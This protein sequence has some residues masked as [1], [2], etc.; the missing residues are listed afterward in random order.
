VSEQRGRGDVVAGRFRLIERLGR[1]SYGVV[2]SADDLDRGGRVAIKLLFESHRA[3]KKRMQRFAQ[4][5]KILASLSHPNIARLITA[6]VEREDPYV[7]MEL[8]DGEPLHERFESRVRDRREIPLEAISWMTG[9]LCAAIAHAHAHH[10]VHRDLKPRNVIVNRRGQRPFLKVLDFG[11]AKLL[12]KSEVDPTTAGVMVGSLAY[13]APEQLLGKT[14]D[15]RADIFSLATLLFEALTLKRPWARDDD[16]ELLAWG[17][18][19]GD[20]E[21]NSNLNVARRILREERPRASQYRTDLSEDVDEVL[22]RAMAI[23]PAERFDD[24]ERFG[25]A[26]RDALAG[27]KHAAET[28]RD[29]PETTLDDG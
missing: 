6:D 17:A 2:W 13:V 15:R 7:A 3:D 25:G 5:A 10:I 8:I 29:L 11:V 27:A 1:G 9:E 20:A 26:L 14:I 23:E 22:L 18:G 21:I 24:V 4:E 28:A 12:V 16:G 19:Y